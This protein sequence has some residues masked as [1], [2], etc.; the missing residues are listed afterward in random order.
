VG[1]V[2]VVATLKAPSR[3]RTATGLALL[4]IIAVGE[5]SALTWFV[6]SDDPDVAGTSPRWDYNQGG[7]THPLIWIA[8]A[9]DAATVVFA[10]LALAAR[11]RMPVYLPVLSVVVGLIAGGL[12]F[13]GFSL[14]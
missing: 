9:L 4:A 13:Y 8:F 6:L 12:A 10:S 3:I 7:A 1:A 11:V 5:A 2:L 14:E